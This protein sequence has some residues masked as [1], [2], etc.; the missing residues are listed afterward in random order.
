MHNEIH[1][2]TVMHGAAG[3]LVKSKCAITAQHNGE[4]GLV[5][6]SLQVAGAPRFTRAATL[7][8][9]A[10]SRTSQTNRAVADQMSTAIT[11][12][13]RKLLLRF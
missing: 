9:V 11:D 3:R 7:L 13:Q 6:S 8:A 4:E 10:V 2:Q 5:V 12:P 1:H